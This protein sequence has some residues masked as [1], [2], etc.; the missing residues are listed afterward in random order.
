MIFRSQVFDGLETHP[1]LVVAQNTVFLNGL[2]RSFPYGVK[3]F[4]F[5]ALDLQAH[6]GSSDL[7][8]TN[9][10][11]RPRSASMA[12]SP[13]ASRSPSVTVASPSTALRLRASASQTAPGPAV[14]AKAAYHADRELTEQ[15]NE[16]V[17]QKY[18][19][20]ALGFASHELHNLN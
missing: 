12:V 16:D 10:C 4:A 6:L 2:I 14:S 20:G 18:V 13:F 5:I 11:S 15:L 17:R 19:K 3:F 1:L 9:A 8:F 7:V